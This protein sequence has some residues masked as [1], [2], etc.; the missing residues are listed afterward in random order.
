[1]ATTLALPTLFT[2]A[3]TSRHRCCESIPK[4]VSLSAMDST[5]SQCCR[6]FG[7]VMSVVDINE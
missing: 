3:L 5:T 4:E 6:V 7:E 2:L 1:M